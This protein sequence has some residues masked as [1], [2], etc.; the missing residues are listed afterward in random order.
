MNEAASRLAN[1]R[2]VGQGQEKEKDYFGARHLF[3]GEEEGE[4]FM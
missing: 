1:G 2:R 4:G 3:W